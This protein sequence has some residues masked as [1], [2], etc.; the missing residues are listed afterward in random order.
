MNKY[1][2]KGGNYY[3][4]DEGWVFYM[5]DDYEEDCVPT[6][7]L[8]INILQFDYKRYNIFINNDSNSAV[9]NKFNN[10]E[11]ADEKDVAFLKL[12]MKKGETITEEEWNNWLNNNVIEKMNNKLDEISNFCNLLLKNDIYLKDEQNK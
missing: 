1:E 7:I 2:L 10:Y 12:C 11:L 3:V 5:S 9:S 8:R 4:G 6:P